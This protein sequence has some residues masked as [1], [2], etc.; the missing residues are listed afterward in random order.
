MFNKN[1]RNDVCITEVTWHASI[2][3]TLVND[4]NSYNSKDTNYYI[5][6]IQVNI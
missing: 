1:I 2:N 3:A 5:N 4:H 6:F